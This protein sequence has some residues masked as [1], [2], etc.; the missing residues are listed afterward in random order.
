M[1]RS[2]EMVPGQWSFDSWAAWRAGTPGTLSYP[3]PWRQV[4]LHIH[5]LQ[6]LADGEPEA[7]RW[8]PR[9]T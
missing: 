4:A 9:T 6:L 1:A 8:G 3:G 5:H 2:E 7:S